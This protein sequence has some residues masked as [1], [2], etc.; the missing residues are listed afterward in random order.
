MG[1][2][3]QHL[4]ESLLRVVTPGPPHR[5]EHRRGGPWRWQ[6]MGPPATQLQPAFL[7]SC[8]LPPPA[9]CFVSHLDPHWDQLTPPHFPSHVPGS[10]PSS[11]LLQTKLLR[12]VTLLDLSPPFKVE[13]ENL[14][15]RH[16]SPEQIT[17]ILTVSSS[18][19]DIY[20][21]PSAL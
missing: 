19:G 14:P 20:G 3:C 6:V 21:V 2:K 17:V 11:L 4:L 8:G 15:N 9:L 1:T 10:S 16:G 5:A 7:G 18:K 12:A 13:M